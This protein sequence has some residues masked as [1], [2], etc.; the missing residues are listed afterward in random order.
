MC[1]LGPGR[2]TVSG[3]EGRVDQ[4]RQNADSRSS[5]NDFK[6][7]NSNGGSDLSTDSGDGAGRKKV[8]QDLENQEG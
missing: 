6:F 3:H 5:G 8:G 2:K 4:S 7:G 1:R